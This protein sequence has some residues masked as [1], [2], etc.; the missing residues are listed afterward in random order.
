MDDIKKRVLLFAATTGYQTRIFADAVLRLGYEL[1]LATDRCCKMENAWGDHA[2]HVKFHQ[3]AR[4]APLLEKEVGRLDAI[5]AVGD[6]PTHVA[7][8]L[9][10]RMGLAYNSPESVLA[11]RNKHRARVRFAAAGLL[12]PA[13][14]RLRVGEDPRTAAGLLRYPVVLKPLG[15][16]GSR[17]V[18]RADDEAGFLAAFRR[19][20]VILESPDIRRRKDHTDRVVQ[21]ETYIP[22]RELALEGVLENGILRTLALFDKPDPLEGPYFE[23]TIYVT[24]SREPEA[25]KTAIR[26]TTQAAVT[27]LGLE[28]GPVHAEMRVNGDG[29]WMLEVA[30]RPIG[31]LCAKTLR[32]RERQSPQAEISLEELIVR[33]AVGQP[34]DSLSLVDGASGVMMI[35]IPKAG[36]YRGVAG[37][38]EAR[39][40]ERIEEVAITATEGQTLLPLPEGNSYLGFLFARADDAVAVEAALRRAH[41][42]LRFDIHSSL[43]VMAAGVPNG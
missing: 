29:V 4:F 10:E 31:G 25:V 40:V 21:V 19:I 12:T 16:S 34:I 17:G 36:V 39:R 42:L 22:G 35:P 32:F 33:H 28:R 8:I 14:L 13:H 26:G 1:V 15:L 18:I 3:A 30:A 5:L 38:E 37:V 43:P 24:P 9:A 11:A 23:E 20:R 27:A 6:L 41:A 2:L 7:A